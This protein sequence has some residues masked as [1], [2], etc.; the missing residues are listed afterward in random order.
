[1][2]RTVNMHEAKT[3]LSQLVAEIE[4]TGED[5][6]LARNGKPVAKIVK[7]R[8]EPE[9]QRIGLIKDHPAW[10]DFELDLG[11]FAPLMTDEDLRREGYDV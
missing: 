1:M 4:A 10:K 8:P 9:M 3:R 11:V 2:S 6:V 7:L 5:I